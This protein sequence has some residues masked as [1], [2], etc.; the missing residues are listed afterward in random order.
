MIDASLC[1]QIFFANKH[2]DNMSDL[3]SI[4][5]EVA[6]SISLEQVSAKKDNAQLLLEEITIQN[7]TAK[8]IM[9]AWDQQ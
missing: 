3:D 4:I 9:I 2:E 5:H 8:L 6:S 7:G 1:L